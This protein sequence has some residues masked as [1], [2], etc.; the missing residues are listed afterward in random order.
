[1]AVVLEILEGVLVSVEIYRLSLLRITHPLKMLWNFL[2][3]VVAVL[4]P[5]EKKSLKL[6]LYV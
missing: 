5:T 6:I 3:L 4:V 1:M 2:V